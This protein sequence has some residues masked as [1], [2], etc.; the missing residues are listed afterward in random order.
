[1][2][3]AFQSILQMHLMQQLQLSFCESLNAE[4]KCVLQDDEELLKW[5]TRLVEILTVLFLLNFFQVQS[6]FDLYLYL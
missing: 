2:E 5:K 4:L 3:L 1:M 6:Y